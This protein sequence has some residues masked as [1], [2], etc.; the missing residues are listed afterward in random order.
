MSPEAF[1]RACR[2]HAVINLIDERLRSLEQ[3]CDWPRDVREALAEQARAQAAAELL[4][5]RELNAVLDGLAAEGIRPI[6]VKG[7]ALAYSVYDTPASRPRIDTDLL[8]PRNHADPVR[9]VMARSGYTM[10]AYCAGELLFGQFP[11]TKTDR[12]GVAHTFD[13]HWKISTQ[14]VFADLLTF[15]E[16]AA[17]AVRLPSIG[18]HARAAG[19]AHALLLACVHPV[20][21]HRNVESLLWVYD[22]HLLASRLSD[23]DLDRFVELA[24]VRQV[25]AICAHQLAAA[26]D[27]FGTSIPD[28]VIARLGVTMRGEP[29]AAYLRT[30][31]R[32]HN[33]LV[34]NVRGLP[35]WTDRVRLLR[36][37]L[38]PGPAYMLK[39]YG[40][41]SSSLAAAL[42]PVLYAHRL[43]S[44]SW[45]VLAGQ[46]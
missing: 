9:R 24:V 41:Q 35:R 12:F 18:V 1:L 16:I 37:V 29:S 21:H 39:A 33:E 8:I 31:R 46:K 40:L 34:S 23:G 32:W 4:R 30:G 19:P 10:P 22:V 7:T 2:D 6:V 17:D 25:A 43:A 3:D 38:L 28:H 44:G 14:A 27:R 42:L 5:R 36:E 20:M 13:F 15:D 45:K 26:R 11:S